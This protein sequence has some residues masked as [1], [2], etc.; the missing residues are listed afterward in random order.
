MI[1]TVIYFTYGA[2]WYSKL[3]FGEIWAKA[4]N[5]DLDELKAE[6]KIFIR[7]ALYAFI[8][9]LFLALLLDL[10]GIYDFITIFLIGL[11]LGVIAIVVGLYKVIYEDKN[12]K[13]YFI[14]VGYYFV[15]FTIAGFIL[16]SWQV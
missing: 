9:T 11:I 13:A 14:E 6:P 15:A 10:I 8:I 12:I 5:F 1:I 3:L 16:G 4:K 2:L 7:V